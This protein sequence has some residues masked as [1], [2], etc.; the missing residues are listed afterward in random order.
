MLILHE[1]SGH[2]FVSDL[3]QEGV[4]HKQSMIS[5]ATGC[6]ASDEDGVRWIPTRRSL[7]AN[8]AVSEVFIGWSSKSRFYRLEF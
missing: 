6:P 4:C 8:G 2:C 3:F 7:L 1:C 5:M